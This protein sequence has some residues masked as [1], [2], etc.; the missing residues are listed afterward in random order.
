VI[1][2]GNALIDMVG[3]HYEA[4]LDFYGLPLGPRIARKHL[5]WY[6]DD[7]GTPPQLRKMM[8]TQKDPRAVLRDLP[9]A[10]TEQVAA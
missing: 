2:Q 10:L 9:D 7:A 3:G 6:M 4:M 1:P 8:L 5:G